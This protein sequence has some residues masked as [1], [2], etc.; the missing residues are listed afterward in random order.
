VFTQFISQRWIVPHKPG[1]VS[2]NPKQATPKAEGLPEKDCFKSRV[3]IGVIFGPLA[4]VTRSTHRD[5]LI[6]VRHHGNQHI[7][8]DQNRQNTVQS[9]QYFTSVLSDDEVLLRA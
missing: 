6:R 4:G 1:T 3:M 7:H 2:C 9:Q 8:S 5:S